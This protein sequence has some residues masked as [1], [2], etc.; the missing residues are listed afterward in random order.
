MP[1]TEAIAVVIQIRL[2]SVCHG[3]SAG[4]YASEG[5]L[6]IY[7]MHADCLCMGRAGR[8]RAAGAPQKAGTRRDAGEWGNRSWVGRSARRKTFERILGVA[9]DLQRP[10]P[11]SREAREAAAG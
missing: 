6:P 1:K 4:D 9:A 2:L 11:S 8:F 10:V 7:P 5:K 3:A